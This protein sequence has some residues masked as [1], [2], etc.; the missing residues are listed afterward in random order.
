MKN[1]DDKVRN[2]AIDIA[3]ALID[4]GKMDEKRAIPIAISKAKEWAEYN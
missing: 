3:N 1:L 2:K 4:D